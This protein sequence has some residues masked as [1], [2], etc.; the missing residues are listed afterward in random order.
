MVPATKGGGVKPTD[1]VSA[2]FNKPLDRPWKTDGGRNRDVLPIDRNS[3]VNK[4]F[5]KRRKRNSRVASI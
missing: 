4:W 3:S 5:D 2:A 1:G